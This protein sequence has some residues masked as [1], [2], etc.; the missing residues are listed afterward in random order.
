MEKVYHIGDRVFVKSINKKGEVIS[1]VLDSEY[2][3]S[4]IFETS[5]GDYEILGVHTDDLEYIKD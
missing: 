5:N 4:V 3:Y 2:D 1:T